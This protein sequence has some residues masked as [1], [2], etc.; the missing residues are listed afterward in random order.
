MLNLGVMEDYHRENGVHCYIT[1]IRIHP[2]F[3]PPLLLESL[4]LNRRPHGMFHFRYN[5]RPEFYKSSLPKIFHLCRPG[6]IF[7]FG[8]GRED[9]PHIA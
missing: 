4:S 2:T 5:C 8:S 9:F 1:G 3:L 7:H 6:S